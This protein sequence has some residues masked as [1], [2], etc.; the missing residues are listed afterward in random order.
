MAG[1]GPAQRNVV[2]GAN[3]VALSPSR[4][5][6]QSGRAYVVSAAPLESPDRQDGRECCWFARRGR[7]VVKPPTAGETD[8]RLQRLPHERA[9]LGTVAEQFL[10]DSLHR[11]GDA[12]VVGVGFELDQRPSEGRLIAFLAGADRHVG[13]HD[14]GANDGELPRR[15]GGPHLAGVRA[16]VRQ[17]SSLVVAHRHHQGV[18]HL[19]LAELLED[20]RH[21][22]VGLEGEA[23]VDRPDRVVGHLDHALHAWQQASEKP[24]G[25]VVQRDGILGPRRVGLQAEVAGE[26][27]LRLAVTLLVRHPHVEEAPNIVV[28]RVWQQ[29]LDAQSTDLRFDTLGVQQGVADLLADDVGPADPLDRHVDRVEVERRLGLDVPEAGLQGVI[30]GEHATS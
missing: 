29:R 21:A 17:V 19:V 3:N 2:G 8:A 6:T 1:A 16:V 26:S 4:D 18:G 12:G 5:G 15:Q 25:P 13:V 20:R 22:T 9:Q 30:A 24:G 23:L 14:Q 11:G 10:G 7:G 28:R 27:R